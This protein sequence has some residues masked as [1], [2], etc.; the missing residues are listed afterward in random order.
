VTYGRKNA[1]WNN[2]DVIYAP[3]NFIQAGVGAVTRSI[4]SKARE[5]ISAL[6]FGAMGDG[7]TDDTAPIQAAINTIAATGNGALYLPGGYSY[8]ASGLT[9]GGAGRLKIYGDGPGTFLIMGTTTGILFTATA[10]YV[11]IE[12]MSVFHPVQGASTAG[13]F[14]KFSNTL[15]IIR[16]VQFFNGFNVA[17]WEDGCFQGGAA[18]IT[19]R[20]LKNDLFQVDVSPLAG[21]IGGNMI[22][23][24]INSQAD[25]TNIG[26]GLRLVSGDGIHVINSAILGFFN[27]ISAIPSASRNYLANLYFTD[28]VVDGAGGPAG[29]GP[30]WFFDGT[31]GPL[32]RVF[33]SNCW[34]GAIAGGNGVEIKNTKVF[35]WV[36][37]M[38]IDCGQSGIVVDVGSREVSLEGIVV[39]GNSALSSSTYHGIVVFTG[40][41]RVSVKNC[42]SGATYNGTDGTTQTNTQGYGLIVA[43]PGT[44]NYQLIGNDVSGNLTAGLL[45]N[46]GAGGRRI[47]RDNPGYNPIGISNITLGAS[48]ATYTAKATPETVYIAGGTVSNITIGGITVAVSVGT[49]PVVL[50]LNPNQ[51]MVVT[52]TAAPTITT[53]NKQ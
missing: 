12:G 31:S 4:Q 29:Q 3:A 34:A 47:V 7:V 38:I 1:A 18:N 24:R 51:S 8:K 36:L 22:F 42:R 48:P 10:G 25:S 17:R 43:D 11:D 16:N 53:T 14:F 5:Q 32:L 23:E 39:T 9:W 37:G 26:T 49:I 41:D 44:T 33:M 6:D 20:G 40:S 21:P 27:G 2:L 13:Y 35:S 45:D 30:G 50:A 28:V 15:A 19:A 46:G 52:Y